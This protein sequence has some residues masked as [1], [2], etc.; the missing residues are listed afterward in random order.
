MFQN[1]DS[2]ALEAM[3]EQREIVLIDVRTDA[4]V[5]RGIIAGARHIP[6][7]SLPQHAAAL[8]DVGTIVVYCQSGGRSAQACSYLAQQGF[9]DLYNLAGGILAWVRDGNSLSPGPINS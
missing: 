4:E 8:A 7:F 5:A 3:R 2:T 6:L 1:I 9:A